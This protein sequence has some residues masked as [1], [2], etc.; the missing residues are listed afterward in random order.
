MVTSAIHQAEGDYSR[1]IILLQNALVAIQ[2]TM[3]PGHPLAGEVL[4]RIGDLYIASEDYTKAEDALNR[5]RKILESSLGKGNGRTAMVLNSL[6]ET[7]IYRGSYSQAER[8]C[9]AALDSLTQIFDENHPKIMHVQD[10]VARLRAV[11]GSS[12]A[13]LP[14]PAE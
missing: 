12:A 14:A 1:S 2:E 6:A 3:G 4:S 5:A 13:K 7:C 8:L 9:Q 10:T 11:S